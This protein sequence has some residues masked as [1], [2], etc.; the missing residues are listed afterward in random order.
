MNERALPMSDFPLD[1]AQLAGIIELI[2]E[3][4]INYSLA[5]KLRRTTT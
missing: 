4:K 2:D 3:N 5:S 1:P